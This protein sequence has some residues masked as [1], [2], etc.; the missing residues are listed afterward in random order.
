MSFNIK[1]NERERRSPTCNLNH[2]T[3]GVNENVSLWSRRFK[4]LRTSVSLYVIFPLSNFTLWC[5][6][7]LNKQSHWHF[8][9]IGVGVSFRIYCG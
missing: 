8:F 1:Q 2:P 5:E 6:K 9:N 3:T 7:R 4:I